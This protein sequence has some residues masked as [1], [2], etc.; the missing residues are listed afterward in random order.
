MSDLSIHSPTNVAIDYQIAP[1]GERSLA[2]VIDVVVATILGQL[3]AM[4]A[5]ALLMRAV[6]PDQFLELFVQV[7]ARIAILLAYFALAEY[8]FEGQTVGKRAL[9]LRTIRLDGA[10]PTF[11]TYGLRT[12]MLF[13]DFL[14]SSGMIGLLAAGSSPLRQRVGDRVA[15]TVVIRGR[16][17]SRYELRDI[18]NIKTADDYEVSFPG[19]TRLRHDQALFLKRLIVRAERQ[20]SAEVRALVDQAARRVTRL[21][22]LEGT[23]ARRLEF[24]RQ[25]LRD[26]IVLTR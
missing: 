4:T 13:L 5:G 24:L 25:V 6:G 2:F 20:N 1:L 10:S 14:V 22:E 11:E 16:P 3:F 23:P 12:A 15:Q 17:Q 8:L 21:L 7:F 18:L 9:G 19:A 26:Y